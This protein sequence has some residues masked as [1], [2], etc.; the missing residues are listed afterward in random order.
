VALAPFSSFIVWNCPQESK[1]ANANAADSSQPPVREIRLPLLSQHRFDPELFPLQAVSVNDTTTAS[2]AAQ[3]VRKG[4]ALVYQGDYHN[5]RQ[6]LSAMKRRFLQKETSQRKPPKLRSIKE[7]WLQQRQDTEE[8]A[9]KLNMLLLQVDTDHQILSCRRRAPSGLAQ[10]LSAHYGPQTES[11]VI[12]LREVVGMIGAYEW[13][14]NGVWIPQIQ[15][16]LYPRYSVF[17]PTRCEYLDLLLQPPLPV[18]SSSSSTTDTDVTMLEVGVGIGAITAIMMLRRNVSYV[19]GTDINEAAVHCTQDNLSTLGLAADRVN[20]V[21]ADIF[22]T[23]AT[24][25]SRGTSPVDLIVCNPPWLPG[26]VNTQLDW[27]IYD[28]NVSMLRRFLLE[29]RNHLRPDTG[30]V[31]LLLSNLSELLELRSRQDL[32]QMIEDG[33]LRIEEILET[34]PVH[35]KSKLDKQKKNSNNNK[36]NSKENIRIQKARASEVTLLF[37]LKQK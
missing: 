19:I 3:L 1:D 26:N 37:R 8:L 21:Q 25:Q 17:V 32:L 13:E 24:T 28:P 30:E 15:Q 29:A 22:P 31:W 9:H 33:N 36:S 7:L 34:H 23:T 12:P 6:L 11:Y 20:I 10:I 5:A 16:K 2:T 35:A 18:A 14:K 4:K 27:A